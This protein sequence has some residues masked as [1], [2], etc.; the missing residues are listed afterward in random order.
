[1]SAPKPKD[2]DDRT[3]APPVQVARE[4]ERTLSCAQVYLSP[5]ATTAVRIGL[6][7]FTPEQVAE[8]VEAVVNGM[9][10]KFVTKKWR[11]VRAVHIKGPNTMALPIWLAEELWVEEEDVLEDEEARLRIEAGKQAGKRK[12]REA[13]EGED[14]VKDGA[15]AN[16]EEKKK[17]KKKQKEPT[18]GKA[19]GGTFAP[20]D[21]VQAGKKRKLAVDDDLSAEMKDRRAKLRKQKEEL[22]AGVV[23]QKRKSDVDGEVTVVQKVKKPKVKSTG[24]GDTS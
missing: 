23:G 12:G 3:I 24:G 7:S 1:M 18:E 4:I 11:N 21:E 16:G 5:A 19:N 14:G 22:R 13:K 8:N 15:A 2:A 10:E 9:V 6:A 20:V 17:K